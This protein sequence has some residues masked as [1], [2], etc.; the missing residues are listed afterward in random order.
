MAAQRRM[1]ATTDKQ[2][3]ILIFDVNNPD[4]QFNYYAG[5]RWSVTHTAADGSQPDGFVDTF[6]GHNGANV[7]FNG[8]IDPSTDEVFASEP[9]GGNFITFDPITIG[10]ETITPVSPSKVTVMAGKFEPMG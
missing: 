2:A 3:N 1:I 8:Y 7:S 5:D 9:S 6:V 4:Y 10:G